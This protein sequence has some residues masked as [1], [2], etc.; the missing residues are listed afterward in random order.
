VTLF[1]RGL[2]LLVLT[3]LYIMLKRDRESRL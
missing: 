2:V 3:V 1:F